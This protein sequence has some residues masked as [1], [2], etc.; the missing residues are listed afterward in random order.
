[1][2]RRRQ[3]PYVGKQCEQ[4]QRDDQGDNPWHDQYLHGLDPHHFERVDFLT[5]LHDADFGGEGGTRRTACTQDGRD[6]H[7]HSRNTDT[8]TML[9]V[10]PSLP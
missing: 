2:P 4:R 6:Q 3:G 7:P 8:A 10:R 1:M 5:R 9:M